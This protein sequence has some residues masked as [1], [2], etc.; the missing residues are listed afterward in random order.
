MEKDEK[1]S[2][3]KNESSISQNF[4]R[5]TQG[6]KFTKKHQ[7]KII[8]NEGKVKKHNRL[9]SDELL[10]NDRRTVGFVRA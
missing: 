7:G 3:G 10:S 5:Y 8:I 9:M 2:K 6:G 1:Q 4:T